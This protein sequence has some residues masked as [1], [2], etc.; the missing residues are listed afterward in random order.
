M[1]LLFGNPFKQRASEVHYFSMPDEEHGIE[2]DRVS[3][4]DC[5]MKTVTFFPS[6][7]FTHL[8]DLKEFKRVKISPD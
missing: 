5:F 4:Q 7:Y 6:E 3:L 8:Q 2:Y 1:A